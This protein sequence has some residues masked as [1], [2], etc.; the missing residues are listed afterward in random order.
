MKLFKK[1]IPYFIASICGCILLLL[2]RRF[3]AFVNPQFHAEEGKYFFAQ[4]YN[5][6]W[7]SLFET[8]NG[9][10]HLWPRFVMNLSL[11]LHIPPENIPAV[12]MAM[13]LLTYL[14][15][16]YYIFTRIEASL[17][18]RC[19]AVLTTV[20]LPLGNEILMTMTNIQ[21]FMAL[22]PPIILFGKR[23]AT[24]PARTFD[25]IIIG[26]CAFTGPY[27]LIMLP[28]IILVVAWKRPVKGSILKLAPQ[29]TLVSLG[30]IATGVTLLGFGIDR[31]EG[32]FSFLN[33][34][35]LQYLF[36]QTWYPLLSTTIHDVPKVPGYVLGLLAFAGIALVARRIIRNGNT[37]F[38]FCLF[39]SF[40]FFLITCISYRHDPGALTP[41]YCGIRNFYLPSVFFIWASL[42]HLQF[43]VYGLRLKGMFIAMGV[44]F[45]IQTVWL[46][47]P[48]RFEDMRWK[49]EV[50]RIGVHDTT[51]IPINPKG[52]SLELRKKN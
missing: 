23:P 20:I 35:F 47:G 17:F 42:S 11:S 13:V 25:T 1:E 4:A 31:T 21:W 33:D 27:V 3:D 46:I 28:L 16:W 2:F 52:W 18:V 5:E 30:A 7:W 43:T 41:F 40:L 12:M 6:G 34:G 32:E 51:V 26:L 45:V 29:L 19:A 39:A 48:M 10:F 44:W 22:L 49:E 24:S 14:A 37:F 9:Y 36:F 15:L 8:A 50:K 38:V